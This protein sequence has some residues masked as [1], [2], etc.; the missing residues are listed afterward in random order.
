MGLRSSLSKLPEPVKL[1]LKD[2]IYPALLAEGETVPEWHLQAHDREWHRQGVYWSVMQFMPACPG[3]PQVERQLLD[4][5][6]H[7]ARFQ[8]LDARVF[9]I[10]PAEETQLSALAGRLGL[11]FAL[12]TDR[13]ASV[14][15]Q[16]R[17]CIQL[18]LR[19]LMVPAMYLVN[20]KREVRLSNRGYPSVEA[21]ARSIEAL[22]QATRRGM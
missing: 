17:A 9:A 18:P 3:D 11:D 20:P 19:P 15:R 10:L 7:H 22:Q 14:S 4:M 21:V 8:E 13:G 1:A 12:L 2:H 5:Q 6:K 16:F